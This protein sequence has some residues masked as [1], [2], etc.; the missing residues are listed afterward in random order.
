MIYAHQS[1]TS[2]HSL[3][4][5]KPLIGRVQVR[6]FFHR[7]ERLALQ[8]LISRTLFVFIPLPDPL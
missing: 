2:V 3:S 7:V 8:G 1:C 5:Y 6:G 4:E